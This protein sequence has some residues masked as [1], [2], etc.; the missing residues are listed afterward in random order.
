MAISVD[1]P[2][3]AKSYQVKDDAAGKKFRCKQCEAIV[4]VPDAA[5]AAQGDPWDNLDLGTQ[6]DP[7]GEDESPFEAPVRPRKKKSS[8]KKGRGG[9]MPITVMVAI[10]GEVALILL[11]IVGVFGNLMEQNVGGACGSIFRILIE[12]AAIIGYVQAQN[13]ARWTAVVLSVLGILVVL[14]CGAGLLI[15]GPNLPPQL[16]QQFPQELIVILIAVFVIQIV[17]WSVIIGTLVSPSAREYFEH[18]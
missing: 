2:S 12:I 8:R 3:C 16:Q 14:A 6:Q 4:S 11:N 18:R 13:S 5:S 15:G 1:C 7:H 10:G 9:G 17:I